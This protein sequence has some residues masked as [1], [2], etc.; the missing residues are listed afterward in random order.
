M[1]FFFHFFLLPSTVI[2]QHLRLDRGSETGIMAT[3][4][5]YLRQTH[6]DVDASNTVHYGPSTNNKVIITLEFANSFCT[7]ATKIKVVAKRLPKHLH[8]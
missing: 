4:H 8:Q 1:P 5:A 7:W 6:E 2:S 3:I